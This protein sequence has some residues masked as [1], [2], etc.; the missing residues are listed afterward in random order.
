MEPVGGARPVSSHQ[1]EADAPGAVQGPVGHA[2]CAWSTGPAGSIGQPG[3]RAAGRDG[4]LAASRIRRGPLRR[5]VAHR[6]ALEFDP[7]RM[8]E[9]AITDG[10][11]ERRF[12]DRLVPRVDRELARDQRRSALAPIFDHLQEVAATIGS[13]NGVRLGELT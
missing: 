7:M 13:I 10:I 12:A 9:Q 2:S 3:A 11:G 5:R 1:T 8:M 4:P 6:G